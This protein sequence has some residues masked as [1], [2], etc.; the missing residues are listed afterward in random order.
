MGGRRK[1]RL[2]ENGHQFIFLY[3]QINKYGRAVF[4]LNFAELKR[5]HW[6]VQ[7]SIGQGCF[8]S[9]MYFTQFYSMKMC[10]APLRLI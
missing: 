5:V 6:M 3:E 10:V 4:L 7:R 9:N 2:N 1:I 8:E